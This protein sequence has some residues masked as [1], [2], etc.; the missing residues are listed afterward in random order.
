M[1][2]T[3]PSNDKIYQRCV[4]LIST[5][6]IM[7]S[8]GKR[9]SLG[10][11]DTWTLHRHAAAKIPEIRGRSALQGA[12]AADTDL[13]NVSFGAAIELIAEQCLLKAIYRSDEISQEM[14][15]EPVS[16]HIRAFLAHN[17]QPNSSITV[18]PVAF[19]LAVSANPLP[20]QHDLGITRY[21]Y[22]S[23]VAKLEGEFEISKMLCGLLED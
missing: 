14:L 4:A 5:E 20:D 9:I 11:M 15:Q 23:A 2:N 22:D 3:G 10:S 19:L 7:N 18:L 17:S 1:I 12:A 13:M 16:S 21:S 8:W 6:I